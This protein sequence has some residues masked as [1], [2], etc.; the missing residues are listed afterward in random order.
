MWFNDGITGD[1]NHWI[2]SNYCKNRNLNL[3][4]IDTNKSI[5]IRTYVQREPLIGLCHSNF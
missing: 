3:T 2:K 5:I 1:R 4:K